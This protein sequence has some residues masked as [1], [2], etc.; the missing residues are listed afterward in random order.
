VSVLLGNGDGTFRSAVRYLTGLNPYGVAVGDFNGD[1]I[2]DI[3]TANSNG[4]NVSVL[5][6]NGDGTFQPARNF[7]V[8][9]FPASLA[10]GDFNRDGISDLVTANIGSYGIS[11]LMANGDGTFQPALTLPGPGGESS[12]VAVAVG[13]F[14]GDGWPD[15]VTA[16]FGSNDVSVLLNDANWPAPPR[17]AP[18]RG[19]G[20][21][22]RSEGGFFVQF[23]SEPLVALTAIPGVAQH[24]PTPDEGSTAPAPQRPALPGGG[25][26]FAARTFVDR[27]GA[28]VS[29][30]RQ[31]Q[32]AGE[33][34][35]WVDGQWW[36]MT[37]RKFLS[38][39]DG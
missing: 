29:R 13:D 17:P 12:P 4:N 24:G 26:L 8:G 31:T 9:I 11:V 36:D 39:M 23:P 34:W 27:R 32:L 37:M 2:L 14:N 22:F 10:V 6:G 33:D 18:P 19:S 16:N 15:L 5:L 21:G 30:A 38:G 7:A 1:G 28:S 35:W 20:P 25:A 3:V